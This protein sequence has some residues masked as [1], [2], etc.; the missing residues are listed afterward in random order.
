MRDVL[1]VGNALVDVVADV[2][3]A[4]LAANDVMKGV[5]TLVDEARAE[6]LYARVGPA[7]EV[8]G[9]SAANTAAGLASLGGK[10]GFVGK[11]RDDQL[12]KIFRHDL[13]AQGVQFNTSAAKTGPATGRC[14]SVVTP[15]AQRSMN[16]FLGAC[17]NLTDEDIK[18]GEI[19]QYR[20][21]YLEGY[22]FDLPKPREA[23]AKTMTLA[24][25][26]GVQVALTLSDSW[27]IA[28]HTPL[29]RD[30]LM[31]GIDV[32]FA[33][34]QELMTLFPAA[35]V[36]KAVASAR[37]HARL[38]VCTQ[39]EKGAIVSAAEETLHSPAERV[40]HVVDTTGAGDMFAAGFLFGLCQNMPLPKAARVGH[41]CAGHI[42]Q[43]HGARP[44]MALSALLA[45]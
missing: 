2:D 31:M 13:T 35:D 28:R 34:E 7:V 42:I 3:D 20:M 11:V 12:G 15:D 39:S 24:K 27:L 36:Q 4:W 17:E 6:A 43:H 21:V 40:S 18:D 14:L 5:M 8:S 29:F 38:V 22:P 33:N 26:H 44:K 45:V 9:G 1:A 10:A 32:L 30:Y 23:L 37:R 25:S 41:L 19:S 16:T